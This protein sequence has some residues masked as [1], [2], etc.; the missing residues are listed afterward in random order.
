MN[1]PPEIKVKRPS[2]QTIEIDPRQKKDV[3]CFEHMPASCTP[4]HRQNE[5]PPHDTNTT[6]QHR[7]CVGYTHT[8]S[9]RTFLWKPSTAVPTLGD[10][11]SD[12]NAA[13]RVA[14]LFS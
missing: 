12:G 9:S 5:I 6:P 3:P 11:R 2:R 1:M 14:G 8:A 10:T 13:V 4:A 7:S